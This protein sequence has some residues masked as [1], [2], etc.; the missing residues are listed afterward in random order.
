MLHADVLKF[1]KSTLFPING[2]KTL[3]QINEVTFAYT[4]DRKE[5]YSFNG[6]DIK[7]NVFSCILE[8]NEDGSSI[9]RIA[10]LPKNH[11]ELLINK[12]MTPEDIM[13]AKETVIV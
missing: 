13:N 3:L 4:I 8:S 2:I 12:S 7:N 11:Y 1:I 5:F 10:M 6:T 9:E